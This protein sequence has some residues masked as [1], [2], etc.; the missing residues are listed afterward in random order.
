MLPILAITIDIDPEIGK[1]GPFLIT[2]HGV[3]TAI[4]IAVAVILSAYFATR[5]GVL[6]DD[7]YNVALWAVPGGI[8]GARLLFVLEHASSF[9]HDFR[10]I[11]ALNEGGIAIYGGLIGG[12]L[13]GW[14]YAYIKR[15]PM[16]R[17]SD[18]AAMGMIMGQAIG[19]LGDFINGEHWAKASKLPWSFCYTNPKALVYGPPFPDN[20]CGPSPFYT[21]GVHPVAGLYEPLLLLLI[22]GICLYLRQVMRKE[23]Y[24][25]WVYVLLYAVVRFGLSGLRI[26][27]QMVHF[28]GHVITV[29]QIVALVSVAFALVAISV[30][31]RLPAAKPV[32]AEAAPSVAAR[33]RPRRT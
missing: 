30:I 11:V 6:E 13:A 27:E 14:I 15:L 16:R 29:P 25:F 5:R 23:G 33:P 20:S 19:R 22:F 8:V 3:F 31:R 7:V 24:V 1:F 17:L 18:A 12:A 4:A 26:N 28:S 9:R 32:K 21:R 2:W 10:G